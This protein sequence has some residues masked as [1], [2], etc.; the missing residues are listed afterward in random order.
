MT[1]VV[2]Y[3]STHANGGKKSVPVL[4]GDCV[5]S[6]GGN[7]DFEKRKK[8]YRISQ[9]LVLGFS[10]DVGEIKLFLKQVYDYFQVDSGC[11]I[12]RRCLKKDELTACF[13]DLI[14]SNSKNQLQVIGW[15]YDYDYNK[16]FFVS[17]N[18]YPN[19]PQ[20]VI[21]DIDQLDANQ[22]K[23]IGSGKTTL[24]CVNR[25]E[26][27]PSEGAKNSPDA[28]PLIE[29]M[30]R[31]GTPLLMEKAGLT[32]DKECRFT[33]GTLDKTFGFAYEILCLNKE[34]QFEYIKD[35]SYGV[36]S[37][38]VDNDIL[39]EPDVSYRYVHCGDHLSI[40]RED[41]T[42][43]DKEYELKSFYTGVSPN[44]KKDCRE[45]MNNYDPDC[46]ILLFEFRSSAH[47]PIHDVVF[48]PYE[49]LFPRRDGV[50]LNF[51]FREHLKKH[52]KEVLR[53]LR[54]QGA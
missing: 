2:A 37:Y 53:R 43:N 51:S 46:F 21:E 33:S 34:N 35:V 29:T 13:C 38:D 17:Y 48:Y 42:G 20:L 36:Y 19:Q 15:L 44:S 45:K 3:K 23:I 31:V 52:Y 4:I 30:L 7:R 9:N 50:R 8:I 6:S 11:D 25:F 16:V 32:F 5:I 10:G 1:V 47:N 12:C 54:I 28:M 39:N 49:Y 24:E 27:I 41:T 26:I 14:R 40:L 22:P 18:Y